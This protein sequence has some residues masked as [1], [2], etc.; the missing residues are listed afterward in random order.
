MNSSSQPSRGTGRPPV[1]PL[2]VLA[3]DDDPANL[4]AIEAVLKDMGL[5]AVLADSGSEALKRLLETEFSCVLLDVRMPGIDGLETAALIRKR[6]RWKDLPIIFMT[7]GDPSILDLSQGYALGAVDFVTRP[8]ETEILKGKLKAV[9]RLYADRRSAQEGLRDARAELALLADAVPALISYVDREGRYVTVNKGY[10]EWFG[11]SIESIKGKHLRD[12][13]GEAAFSRIQ[14]MVEEVLAGKKVTFDATLPYREGPPRFVGGSYIPHVVE[15]RVVGFV[16]LVTDLTERRRR[17]QAQVF[18]AEAGAA[19]SSSL[20]CRV[21]LETVARLSVPRIADWCA[22]DLISE[23][24]QVERVATVTE[25]PADL[26]RAS[27]YI[28]ARPVSLR[29][30][31]GIGA[32]LRT[33]EPE[34]TP[35]IPDLAAQAASWHPEDARLIA[36]LGFRSVV[37]VPLRGRER[38]LGAVSFISAESRRRYGLEDLSIAQELAKRAALALENAFLY[39]RVRELNTKL[40][41]LVQERTSELA[42]TRGRFDVLSRISPVGIFRTGPAGD[43]LEV[44][45]R[46]REIAGLDPSRARG[47]GWAA[48]LHPLD[49]ERVSEEWRRAVAEGRPFQ[50]EYRFLRPDGTVTWVLGQAVGLRNPPGKLSGYVG[51]VTD[52]TDR[53]VAEEQIRATGVQLAAANQELEAFIHT[54]AHDLRA[55]LRAMANFGELLSEEYA[56]KTLDRQGQDYVD[57]IVESGRRMDQ[58]TQ[59]LLTYARVS[60]GEVHTETLELGPVLDEVLLEMAGELTAKRARIDLRTLPG[61]VLGARLLVKQVLSNLLY[62]AV[63]FVAPDVV[64]AVVVSGEARGEFVRVWIEDNGI[65]ICPE[66]VGKL[67]RLFER[68]SSRRHYPGTGVGLAVVKR[69]VERFGGAVGVDPAPGGGSRFWFELRKA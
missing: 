12:V 17:E 47:D 59:D 34:L 3:V 21:T 63:K 43:C 19:L 8:I 39:S 7:S 54:I 62:N 52:I 45:E 37:I 49:R 69:A 2:T 67:F 4:A 16:A 33:G 26:A 55:P 10:Q 22:V 23:E 65:G 61:P 30:E 38:I 32:V 40:T 66:D 24:G 18:L 25:N 46:W 13:L 68:L 5:G 20:D 6:E 36:D 44:N 53:K 58:M 56:G 41:S 60:Q 57:R 64:P 50:S 48:A 29:D 31:H 11:R 35:W 15:G 42:D 51:T 1:A 14:P 9:T 28:K 27:E